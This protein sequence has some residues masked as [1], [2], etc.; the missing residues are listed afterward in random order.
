MEIKKISRRYYI[1][2]LKIYHRVSHEYYVNKL[3][4]IINKN[5]IN[6]KY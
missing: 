6:K 2:N 1:N 4:Y 5:N 3:R